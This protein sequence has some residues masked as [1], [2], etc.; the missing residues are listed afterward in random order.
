[1]R[2]DRRLRWLGR[3]DVCPAGHTRTLALENL[4]RD[5][6]RAAGEVVYSRF[7]DNQPEAS[8]RLVRRLL[9]H[10]RLFVFPA[11]DRIDVLTNYPFND[12]RLRR[13]V[14]LVDG[15]LTE[16]NGYAPLPA[17]LEE[18]NRCDLG[19][20]WL[21]PTLLGELLRRHGPFEVLPGGWVARATLGLGTWLLRRAR[22]ALR[23]ANVPISLQEI[24][25]ERP[26]LT[27]FAGCL[28]GLL[29]QDPLVQTPD[30]M[31]FQI[32]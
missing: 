10:N 18:V 27:E 23:E 3:G 5:F 28:E 25:V 1:V 7:V 30:G 29:Q 14:A 9:D 31:R 15:F 2:R 20:G 24:L 17:V 19:G 26:E 4:G 16:R 32:A 22:N 12:E 8:R 13:L 21:T 6:R 11:P